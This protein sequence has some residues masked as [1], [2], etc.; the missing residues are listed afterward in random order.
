MSYSF[1]PSIKPGSSSLVEPLQDVS[2]N[3]VVASMVATSKIDKIRAI[4][5]FFLFFIPITNA[6]KLEFSTNKQYNKYMKKAVLILV[7]LVIVAT[8]GFF[9]F[10][11]NTD[12]PIDFTLPENLS[13]LAL[14]RDICYATYVKWDTDSFPNLADQGLFWTRLD[15]SNPRGFSQ[16]MLHEM[17]GL[18]SYYFNPNKPTAIFVHGVQNGR[19]YREQFVMTVSGLY[20]RYYE[21]EHIN[22]PDNNMYF[23][24]IWLQKGWNL[25]IFHWN[26]LADTSL[27]GISIVS[28]NIWSIDRPGIRDTIAGV[29]Y[30]NP[31]G[32]FTLNV[33][34]FSVSEIFAAD[35]I[36]SV[37]RFNEVFG[38]GVGTEEIRLIG[39]SMGAQV[40][41]AG[42]FLLA[43]LTKA[44]QLPLQALPCRYAMLDPYFGVAIETGGTVVIMN[45]HNEISF[46]D[47]GRF[48]NYDVGETML[49]MLNYF[50]QIGISVEFYILYEPMWMTIIL[51]PFLPRIRQSVSAFVYMVMDFQNQYDPSYTNMANG[52][53][54]I[55][56]WYMASIAFP[57]APD[58]TNPRV[59]AFGP[60]ASLPTSILRTMQN[61]VFLQTGSTYMFPAYYASF[62]RIT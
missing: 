61:V 14:G 22:F 2:K 40:T 18:Y 27:V 46:T 62:I 20:G 8:L 16:R 32:S 47:G 7:T 21:F 10:A 54:A 52:H 39:H 45:L 35:Y 24:V 55:M 4:N 38:G 6:T 57:P 13:S 12:V 11:C 50:R 56:F 29:T 58:V 51:T 59:N 30:R 1:T 44:G 9:M 3:R 53:D 5:L 33:S 17:N 37:N 48:I 42:L 15:S 43:Q 26:R 25:G 23:P 31:Q 28:L 19:G 34:D 60:T 36:R 41:C 49:A